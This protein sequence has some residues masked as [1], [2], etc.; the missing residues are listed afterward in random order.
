MWTPSRRRSPTSRGCAT[1]GYDD[2][3]AGGGAARVGPVRRRPAGRAAGDRR[4]RRRGRRRSPGP[5]RRIRRPDRRS[6]A[7]ARDADL[8]GR[9][10]V[11]TAG[12]TREAIDPV[13]FIGNRSTGKMGVADRRGRARPRGAGDAHRRERRGRAPARAPTVV[14]GRVDRRPASRA[15]ARDPRRATARRVRCAGHGRRRRRLPA[16]RAAPTASSS[17]ATG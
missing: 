6:S 15:P 7:P 12:G 13:R 1:F 17:A 14:A 3:R 4:R 2:R 16:G 11:V 8:A 10:V 9:H 5:C